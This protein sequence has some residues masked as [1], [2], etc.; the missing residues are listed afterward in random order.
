M[1]PA[2]FGGFNGDRMHRHVADQFIHESLPPLPAFLGSG[3]LYA[4]REL[5]DG[6]HGKTY[7]DLSVT[8][9][10]LFQ[11]LPD[12]VAPPLPGDHHAGIED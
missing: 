9:S 4:M 12:G 1:R 3:A 10:I 6:D 2:S 7:F 5:H 8:A 11:N